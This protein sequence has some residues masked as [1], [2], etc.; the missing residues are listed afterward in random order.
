MKDV[1]GY[2]ANMLIEIGLLVATLMP[3][4]WGMTDG[5]NVGI[6]TRYVSSYFCRREM[7]PVGQNAHLTLTYIR[8]ERSRIRKRR[9]FL[10]NQKSSQKLADQKTAN[11]F[12]LPL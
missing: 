8:L 6:A 7:A 11:T 10:A 3:D 2:V 4:P 5:Q 9:R 12:F 1:L